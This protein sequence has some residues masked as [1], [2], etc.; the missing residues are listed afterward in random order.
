MLAH[1]V[2]LAIAFANIVVTAW[3][4]FISPHDLGLLGLLLAFS[5]VVAVAFAA[6]TA[7][8]VL[9]GAVREIGGAARQVAGG[10]LGVRVAPTGPDELAGLARGFNAMAER[11][12]AADR[13]AARWRARPARSC[14]RR[15]PTTCERRWPRSGRWSRRSTTAWSP[16]P[17]RP[18][19]TC[20]SP[21]R[22]R[23]P[24]RPDRRPVRALAARRRRARRSI[25]SAGSL[26]DLVSD[27]LEALQVQAAREGARARAVEVA[28]EPAAGPDGH[29]ANSAGAA[30][31]WSRTRSAT[32]PPDGTIAARGA[33]GADG[34]VRVDVVDSGEGMRHDDLPRIF[35]RFYRG[36]KSRVRGQGGAGLGL[37][38]AQG[39]RGGPRRPDLGAEPG[40]R[41]CALQLHV[42][43]SQP[44]SR[45]TWPGPIATLPSTDARPPFG[46]WLPPYLP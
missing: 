30:T 20:A 42:A 39:H 41:G 4:M 27:T 36:E 2:V 8:Q 19:A 22:G 6:L 25:S 43:Q 12:E 35:E 9:R 1:L 29:G 31:T 46:A 34:Q 11:L 21:G 15:S 44:P 5:A 38:I 7:E 17:R 10:E 28:A 37:A 18:S 26:H 33:G 40:R 16:T 14:S 45:A 13:S 24:E 23:P 3:L 32:P